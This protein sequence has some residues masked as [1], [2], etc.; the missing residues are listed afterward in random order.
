MNSLFRILSIFMTLAFISVEVGAKAFERTGSYSNIRIDLD[1][2]YAEISL[3]TNLKLDTI[4]GEP[5]VL[6]SGTWSFN[7]AIIDGNRYDQGD[8]PSDVISELSLYDVDILYTTTMTFHEHYYVQCDH[9]VFYKSGSSKASTTTATIS[10]WNKIFTAGTDAFNISTVSEYYSESEAK[11]Y[12]KE[13]K[14]KGNLYSSRT[15][16]DVPSKVSD[17]VLNAHINVNSIRQYIEKE[18]KEKE[19]NKLAKREKE[20]KD[21]DDFDDLLAST[22]DRNNNHSSSSDDIFDD[23]TRE[24]QVNNNSNDIFDDSTNGT[25]SESIS[26]EEMLDDTER[27]KL[28]IYDVPTNT[29]KNVITIRGKVENISSIDTSKILFK[30][31]GLEQMVSLNRNGTFENKIVLFN[32]QNDIDIVYTSATKKE[33]KHITIHSSTRPVKA[34]FTLVW[35]SYNSDMDLHVYGPNGDH[36]YYSKQGTSNMNLDVDNT[37]KYGPENI[38]VKLNNTPG[39]YKAY[40]KHYNGN[41]GNVT[42]YI[43]LDNRLIETK[44]SFLS[45]KRKW[46]AYDLIIE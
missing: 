31:N 37:K 8:L 15:W 12:M 44:K 30:L 26:F 5:N 21:L 41:S 19:K 7:Y 1:D 45:G 29:N 39:V 17:K 18:K 43:Y 10:N 13:L 34:R 42:L 40:I 11:K 33:Q 28:L 16:N 20:K 3:K 25:H 22:E 27:I 38:S 35:D 36:C 9:G 46:H 32:G 14:E 24:R 4:A 6:C 23:S 2:G